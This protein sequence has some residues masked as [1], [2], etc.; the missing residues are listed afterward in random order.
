MINVNQE[1][2]WAQNGT[3]CL[4]FCHSE[5]EFT[6][7]LCVMRL[8]YSPLFT[9]MKYVKR[10][11]TI[12]DSN[13]LMIGVSKILPINNNDKLIALIIICIM[14]CEMVFAGYG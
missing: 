3:P 9:M 4:T 7:L 8:F 2:Q 12:C 11:N 10:H 6:V 1:D 5:T 14:L 13:Y